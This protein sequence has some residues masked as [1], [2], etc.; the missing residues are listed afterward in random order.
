MLAE[1]VEPPSDT[2]NST[3]S[4]LEQPALAKPT[5]CGWVVLHDFK[6][7]LQTSIILLIHFQFPSK[8][9]LPLSG[10]FYVSSEFSTGW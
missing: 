4:G 2:Q 5:W 7:Y 6:R 9:S 3:G 1:V 10:L 8:I